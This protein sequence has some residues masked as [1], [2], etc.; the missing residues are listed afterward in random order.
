MNNDIAYRTI[1]DLFNS[2]EIAYHLIHHLPARTSEESAKAR[3]TAGFPDAVGAKALIVKCEFRDHM[4]YATLVLPSRYRI[5]NRVV[6]ASLPGLKRFRFLTPEEMHELVQLS[7]GCMPPFGNKVFEKVSDLYVD[8]H[9]ADFSQIG[10]NAAQV[11]RSIIVSVSDYLRASVPTAMVAL[12]S[13]DDAPIIGGKPVST[14][15]AI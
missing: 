2:Q 1:Q 5:D 8:P 14:V 4:A 7:P 12:T 11:E 15:V 9:L 13:G 3:S 10:F 6:R